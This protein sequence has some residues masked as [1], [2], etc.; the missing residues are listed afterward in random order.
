MRSRASDSKREEWEANDFATEL[1]MPARLFTEDSRKMDV[2][3]ACAVRLGDENHYDV[4]VTAAAW[5]IVQTTREAAA[6]VVSAH[7]RVE[8]IYRSTAFRL[9]LMERGQQLGED[10][11]AATTFRD[12][13]SNPKP[14]EVDPFSWLDRADDISGT[15]LESTHFVPSLNQTVSLLWL[16]DTDEVVEEQ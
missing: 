2:S 12:H 16:P 4:S 13:E 7:G 14:E 3:I 11:V 5:R 6:M 10:T 9:P 8:W 15:L 1:L